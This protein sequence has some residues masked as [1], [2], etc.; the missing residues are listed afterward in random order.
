MVAS[1]EVEVRATYQSVLWRLSNLTVDYDFTSD[2]FLYPTPPTNAAGASA[3]ARCRD[4]TWSWAQA[5]ADAC[6]ANGGVIYTVCPGVL[7]DALLRP[8]SDH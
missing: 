3:T 4:G 8:P 1:G 5:R 2:V 6:K 7:C